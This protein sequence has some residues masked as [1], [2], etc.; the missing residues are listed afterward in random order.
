MT[1]HLINHAHNILFLIE[2]EGK[3]DILK[4]VLTTSYQPGK[5]PVQIINPTHGNLYWFVDNKAANLLPDKL[6]A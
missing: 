6:L 2:G 1:P 3:A 5:F 4:T